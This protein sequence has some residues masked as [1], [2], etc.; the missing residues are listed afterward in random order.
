MSGDIEEILEIAPN[1]VAADGGAKAALS[2][3]IVPESVIGD[4][5]SLSAELRHSIPS[6]R[7]LHV[8]EQDST[9]FE[10]CLSR[11]SAPLILALGFTG[12][13]LD[14]ELAVYNALSRYPERACIVLGSHDLAFLAPPKVALALAPGDR[15]SLFPMAETTGQSDGLRWPI[16]G[17]RFAPSGRVGT[18]NMAT[19]PVQLSF[20]ALGMLIILPRAALPAARAALSHG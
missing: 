13:R 4:F 20:D 11:I 2:A 12:Q 16:D 10:K 7:L 18:S 19:G 1:L 6:D 14:H 8:S 15:V 5:D 17:L 3:G 9:D